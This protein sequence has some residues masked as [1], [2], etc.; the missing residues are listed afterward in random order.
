[1]SGILPTRHCLT[2]LTAEHPIAKYTTVSAT[3]AMGRH[4]IGSAA[5]FSADHHILRQLYTVREVN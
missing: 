3:V 1:M 4:Y 2:A 5:A